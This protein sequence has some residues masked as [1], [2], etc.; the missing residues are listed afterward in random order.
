[1]FFIHA[2][3]QK[4]L[5]VLQSGFNLWRATFKS[6]LP[7]SMMF[8]TSCM[9]FQYL[10]FNEIFLAVF[11][12]TALADHYMIAAHYSF[13]TVMIMLLSLLYGLGNTAII[14]CIHRSRGKKTCD[15]LAWK[16]LFK[17]SWIVSIIMF[18]TMA[19]Y[20]CSGLF[21]IVPIIKIVENIDLLSNLKLIFRI[22]LV[23]I[24]LAIIT[25][26][27][28]FSYYI[29]IIDS[30][31]VLDSIRASFALVSKY[32]WFSTIRLFIAT[33]FSGVFL[34]GVCFLSVVVLA[35]WFLM[36]GVETDLSGLAETHYWIKV[37][38]LVHP[39][40]TF[41]LESKNAQYLVA[42][43]STIFFNPLGNSFM[44]EIFYDLRLRKAQT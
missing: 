32:W 9:L 37:W 1:M 23:L 13:W 22:S 41:L 31:G 36:F 17:R 35:G 10:S 3:P 40:G 44:L 27:L 25:V 19:V 24:P 43:L 26:Y 7:F 15:G 5:Q 18:S 38:K 21:F 20:I 14:D 8:A 28:S 6:T 11:R 4:T 34:L 16:S 29:A 39:F 2:R 12:M 33:I 30:R 42:W